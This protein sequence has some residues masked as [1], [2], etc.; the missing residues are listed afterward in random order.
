MTS[1]RME[2][3]G[4][5]PAL[6]GPTTPDRP[7][8][9]LSAAVLVIIMMA[10]MLAGLHLVVPSVTE[11]A[12]AAPNPIPI[13]A[14]TLNPSQ[15]QAI[16]TDSQIGAVAFSGTATVDKI[17]GIERMVLTLSAV[18]DTGWPVVIS[19]MTIP[20]VNPG[21]QPFHMVVIVPPS[22]SSQIIGTVMV[23]CTGSVTGMAPIIANANG[24]VTVAQFFKL[25]LETESPLREVS[26]GDLTFNL[27]NVYNDGNSMDT[28]EVE[29]E[30]A[31]DLVKDKW[32]VLLGSTDVSVR[33]EEYVPVKVTIQTPQE[34]RLWAKEIQPIILKATSQEAKERNVLYIKS[35]PV[36]VYMKGYHIP[37]F[38]PFLAII[39]LVIA[40]VMFQGAQERADSRL[41]KGRVKEKNQSP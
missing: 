25:R 30:N 41:E 18:V 27:V 40:V 32:T 17:R 13:V 39:A 22:T 11:E 7:V 15:M 1:A 38:D 24:V 3:R 10:G 28:I 20:F 14:I 21:S 4:K 19:P 8:H 12:E 23:T 37:G 33:S 35:Y 16:I 36:F 2:D 29:I 34:W 26:P 5:G 6:R 31:K 9:G